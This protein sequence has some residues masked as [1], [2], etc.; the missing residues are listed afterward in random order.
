MKPSS[1]KITLYLW[2]QWFYLINIILFWLIGLRYVVVLHPLKQQ[3]AMVHLGYACLIV[4]LTIIFYLGYLATI[5]LL[6]MLVIAPLVI[7]TAYRRLVLLLATLMSSALII[8]Q[9][10]LSN[11]PEA[12][13]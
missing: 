1:D 7:F 5:A 6:P 11:R 13:T 3:L 9:Q 8:S 4:M 10:R 12:T 2:C